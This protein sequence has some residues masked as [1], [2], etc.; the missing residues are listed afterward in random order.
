MYRYYITEQFRSTV[1]IE[2]WLEKD[3]PLKKVV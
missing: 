1:S 2:L 3:P